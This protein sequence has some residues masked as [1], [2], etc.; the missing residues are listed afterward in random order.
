MGVPYQILM[1]VFARDIFHG[2]PRILGFLVAMSGMGALSGA[3]YLAARKSVV[4]LGKVIALAAALFGI[5]IISVSSSRIL[6]FSMAMLFLS[7]FGM[8]VQMASSNTVLQTVV[9]DDKR[10]RVMSFYTMS[11]MGMAP[12][13]S[14]LAGSLAGR[15]GAPNTLLLGGLCCI[16]GAG[17]FAIKL[18]LIRAKVHPIYVKKGII[19]EVAEGIQSAAGLVVLTKD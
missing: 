2:G 13:G 15:I 1:P 17:V 12:F 4:G 19:P 3:I 8:M 10:G 7:G 16:I 6:W 14:L 9:D 11:F 18:P 5:G